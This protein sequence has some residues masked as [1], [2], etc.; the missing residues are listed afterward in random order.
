MVAEGVGFEPTK[1]GN[2]L[3]AFQACALGQTVRSLLGYVKLAAPDHDQIR[4]FGDGVPLPLAVLGGA[5]GVPC[6]RNPLM[7]D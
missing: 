6:T 7:R 5:L 4:S 3:H 2:R 1:R